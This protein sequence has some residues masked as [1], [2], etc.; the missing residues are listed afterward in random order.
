[1]SSDDNDKQGKV[2]YG[3][4]PK[5]HRFKAGKSGNPRGR[6]VKLGRSHTSRQ[7]VRDIL[8]VT[9][10]STKIRTSDGV[11]S[12]TIVEAMLRKAVQKGLEGHAPSQRFVIGLHE[13][14]IQAHSDRFKKYFSFVEMVEDE[15]VIKP[16]PPENEQFHS[17]FLNGLRKKT[18][19]T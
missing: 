6:P 8:D 7:V 15:A 5:E 9:E 11:R 17:H 14:A 16:V 4:P 18:R 13:R 3:K 2:G 1:M 10:S 12:I 19:R